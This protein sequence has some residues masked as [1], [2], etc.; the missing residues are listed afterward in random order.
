MMRTV[1]IDSL[2]LVKGA[3]VDLRFFFA[4]RRCCGSKFRIET[5]IT[6]VTGSCTIWGDPHVDVF[7]NGLFG[8][9]RDAPLGIFTIGDYWLVKNERVQIQARYGYTQYSVDNQSSLVALALDGPFLQNHKLIIEPMAVV[10]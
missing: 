1:A 8:A 9:E 6:P 4:E 3:A 7:D 10:R 5:S 2:N